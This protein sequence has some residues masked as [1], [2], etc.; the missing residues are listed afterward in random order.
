MAGSANN[1]CLQGYKQNGDTK[2]PPSDNQYAHKESGNFRHTYQSQA[3]RDN[4]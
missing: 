1:P 4:S 2:S 3:N